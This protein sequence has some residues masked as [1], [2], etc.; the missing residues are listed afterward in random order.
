VSDA[1]GPERTF[2]VGGAGPLGFAIPLE[3][4]R[5]LV[6][7]GDLPPQHRRVT[8]SR[9]LGGSAGTR[10][11]GP[12][13]AGTA[14]TRFAEVAAAGSDVFLDL[15]ADVRV[16]PFPA[17]AV[18]AMPAALETT[19]RRWGWSGLLRDGAAMRIVLDAR[20]LAAIA[21]PRVAAEAGRS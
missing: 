7:F 16:R 8:L 2:I 9:L 13:E 10:D 6:A 18:E 20:A 21:A 17:E 15:G 14:H 11:A 12:A 5:R 4:V 3:D 19:A 1:A